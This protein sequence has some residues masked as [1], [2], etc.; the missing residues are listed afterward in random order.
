MFL[1]LEESLEELGFSSADEWDVASA[2]E[3]YY[4]LQREEA[5]DRRKV[6]RNNP[7]LSRE[8][9]AKIREYQAKVK[10]DPVRYAKRLVIQ[11]EADKRRR[12]KVKSDPE[13]LEAH[14]NY[15]KLL[16][17]KLRLRN[18]GEKKDKKANGKKSTK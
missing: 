7:D 13:K 14:R 3:K 17:R 2:L 4:G 9:L 1:D 12:E 18:K 15:R 8:N 11:R 5:K 6:I 16:A 10:S